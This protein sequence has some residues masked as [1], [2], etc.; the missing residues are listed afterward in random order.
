MGLS[1]SASI[2]WAAGVA[3]EAVLFVLALRRG[4]FRR[5]PFLT[6]YLGLLL[7][8]EA[9]MWLT[10]RLTGIN[11]ATSA[12]VY[13]IIQATLIIA[14]AVAVYDICRAILSPYRGIWKFCRLFLTGLGV[15]L[16]IAAAASTRSHLQHVIVAKVFTAERGLELMI[17]SILISG[18][19][20][21]RYYGVKV[22]HYLTW[23]MF[24]FGFYSAVQVANDTFLRTPISWHRFTLWQDLRL[25]SFNIATLLWCVA[26]LRPLPEVSPSPAL[27]KPDKYET[28]AP[29][30]S[31]RLRQLNSALLGLWK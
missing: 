29:Q 1:L 27:M 5:L 11:S 12:N 4:L 20:F 16:T 22:D 2:H 23:L 25:V 24:G 14:R 21:C 9:V 19:I 17:L 6:L 8:N 13:W 18:L 31:A 7:A 30:M 10:Y 3:V 15:A 26:L 28:I